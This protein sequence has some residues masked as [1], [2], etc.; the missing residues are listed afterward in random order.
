MTQ[1]EQTFFEALRLINIEQDEALKIL[2]W[3]SSQILIE[4]TPGLKLYKCSCCGVTH[5]Q[6]KVFFTNI[7]LSILI[8]IFKWSV[9]HRNIEFKKSEL[10]KIL[11]HTDYGN[12]YTLQRFWLIYFLRDKE[13]GRKIKWSWGVNLKR[14]YNFLNWDYKIAQFYRRNTATKTNISSR[15]ENILV[16]VYEIKKIKYKPEIFELNKY[17]TEYKNFNLDN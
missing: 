11:N 10:K 6:Y 16:N 2:Q 5:K 3:E 12:F 7:H 15:T 4:D 9:E 13:T 14:I 17:F 1:K 8:K